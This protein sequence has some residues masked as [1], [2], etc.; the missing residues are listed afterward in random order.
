MKAS[1][2]PLPVSLLVAFSALSFVLTSCT[3]TDD[4]QYIVDRAIAVHGGD[5]IE[6]SVIEF[7][8]RGKHFKATR[9]GGA[10]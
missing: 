4:P 5:V 6:H 7:D 10:F 8:Y 1:A 9:D 3:P 2:L